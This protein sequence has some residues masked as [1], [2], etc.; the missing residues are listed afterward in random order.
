MI[1]AKLTEDRGAIVIPL[2]DATYLQEPLVLKDED[3]ARFGDVNPLY[4][5]LKEAYGQRLGPPYLSSGAIVIPLQGSDAGKDLAAADLSA[6]LI[7]SAQEIHANA[8]RSNPLPLKA[9]V[10]QR[11]N[12]RVLKALCDAYRKSGARMLVRHG[13]VEHEVP[14]LDSADFVSA[15]STDAREQHGTYLVYGVVRNW[16]IRRIEIQLTGNLMSVIL[17]DDASWSWESVRHALDEPT[18]YVGG[19]T[20]DGSA[21]PWQVMP[22]ARLVAQQCLGDEAGWEKAD[23]DVAPAAG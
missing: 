12:E 4:S 8:Q 6:S 19:I 2:V 9:V 3:L 16:K 1:K 7:H 5:A 13:A 15:A 18:Y 22:G 20:R 21:G 17:P 14:A 11:G 10:T 23:G